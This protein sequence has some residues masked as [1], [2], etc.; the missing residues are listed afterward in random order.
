VNL[1]VMAAIVAAAVCVSVG[2]FMVVRRRVPE[3]GVFSDGD[4]AAGVFGVL[5]T[6]FS[7]LLGFVVFLAFTSYDTARAGARSEAIDVI[8]QFETAQLLPGPAAAELS[9][10]LVCY[11]RTVANREWAQLRAGEKP[12]FNAWGL[13][14]FESL[15]RVVP[16]TPVE[17]VAYAKW[18]DQT[19]DREQARLDRVQAGAGIIPK[20]L[21]LL[22]FVTGALVFLYVFLFAD[23]AEGVLA[24]AVI[25]ATIAAMLAASLLVIR[26]LDDPYRPGSG[27]L[28]PTEM[29]RV[30]GLL[31][32]ATRTLGLHV[33][34][35]CDA[36]GR[37]LRGR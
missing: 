19:S 2:A 14:L 9:G 10:E 36:D 17:Q 29:R 27:S 13:R 33:R 26:F 3:G 12:S 30:L 31:D 15:Q 35:P 24:Q 16:R 8:Q 18:L 20:P 7:V 11:G 32:E 1:L 5:A 37:A 23:R 25:P 28:R 34:V 22:L 6:G 4:R 21:W